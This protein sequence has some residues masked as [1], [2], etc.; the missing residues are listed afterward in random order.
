MQHENETKKAA[1]VQ[2][3]NKLKTAKEALEQKYEME[4]E[5]SDREIKTEN[6]QQLVLKRTIS[7]VHRDTEK[8]SKIDSI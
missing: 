2:K 7:D 8:T 1:S 4:L 5:K 6:A 3:V